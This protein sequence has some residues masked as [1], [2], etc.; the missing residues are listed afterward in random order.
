MSQVHRAAWVLPIAGPPI[1]NGWVEVRDGRIAAVGAAADLPT[2]GVSS[3]LRARPVPPRNLTSSRGG[4]DP[5]QPAGLDPS[6]GFAAG[7][8]QVAILPGLV[9]AHVHLE[10]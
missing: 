9:N 6:G 4:D 1:R 5:S 3:A 7:V 10:L 2:E 8:P